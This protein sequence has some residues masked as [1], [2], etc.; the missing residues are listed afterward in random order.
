MNQVVQAFPDVHLI[1]TPHISLSKSFI[2]RIH[3]IDSFVQSLKA[4]MKTQ[5][6]Q[7]DLSNDIV[8]FS[9]EEKTR[10]FACILASEWCC[11]DLK[12]LTSTVD[13]CLSEFEL[14][15][16]YENPSWHV[17]VLWKLKEFSSSEKSFISTNIQKLQDDN[18]EIHSK[19]VDSIIC[20]S[21]NKVFELFL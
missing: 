7:L 14:P 17:S 18:H 21:G 1:N 9:N 16:Y 19:L 2:L 12:A 3:W 8:Y 20:K 5:K 10:Y 11:S 15:G 13:N 6:F 4:E